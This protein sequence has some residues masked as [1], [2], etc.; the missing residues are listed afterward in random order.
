MTYRFKDRTVE[1][2]TG[3]IECLQEAYQ[4][5]LSELPTEPTPTLT[6]WYRGV[7]N[8]DLPLLPTLYRDGLNIP[9]S[10]ELYLLNKFKQNAHQFLTERPQGEWE[11]MLLGRHHGLPSRLLDWTE[12]LLAGA[13]FAAGG[14]DKDHRQAD[15]ALWCLLP[16]VLNDI[17]TNGTVRSDVLP[18][19]SDE[20]DSAPMSVFL[21]NYTATAIQAS[22]PTGSV[23]PAAAITIRT[24]RRIQAQ[25]G[26][27]TVHHTDR[28]PLDRWGDGSHLWRFLIPAQSKQTI[29]EDLRRIGISPLVL[30]PD[31]DN[32]AEEA[33]RGY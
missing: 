18:M 23:A 10:D 27:F 17:A 28:A 25:A 30:F 1:T 33:T 4:Q 31:L 11:W 8:Q 20:V 21:H 16:K 24:N 22:P 12:S 5:L 26:V 2:L 29:L 19:L 7:S 9:L 3:L 13:F 6:I 32:A 14:L 15:G